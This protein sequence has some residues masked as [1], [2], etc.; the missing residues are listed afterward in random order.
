ML[1]FIIVKHQYSNSQK[2]IQRDSGLSF[3]GLNETALFLAFFVFLLE[4]A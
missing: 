2:T 3:G 4:P 1:K